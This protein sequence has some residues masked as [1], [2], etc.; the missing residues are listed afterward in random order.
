MSVTIEVEVEIE[1]EVD[2]NVNVV[3]STVSSAARVR[4]VRSEMKGE[5]LQA[6]CGIFALTCNSR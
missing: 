5:G 1:V 3:V 6:E 2:V 4:W